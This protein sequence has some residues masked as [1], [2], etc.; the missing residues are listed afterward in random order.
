[1]EKKTRLWTVEELAAKFPAI[2]FPEY[3]R[4]PSVWSRDAKQRLIDSMM[5]EFDIASIYLYVHDDDSIECIDGRQRMNAIMSFLEDNPGDLDNGFEFR[6]LNEVFPDNG[7]PFRELDK[8]SYKRITQLRDSGE[9]VAAEFIDAFL[10]YELTVVFLKGSRAPE[11]FNLQF[12]RLNLGTII[13]SGEKLHAMVGELRDVCFKDIGKH[14]FFKR[15]RIPTRRYANEQVAA[16]LLVQA[17]SR[18]KPGDEAD[19]TRT[20]HFDLQTAFKQSL[21]LTPEE[22]AIVDRTRT[23]LDLL[24]SAFDE[25]NPLRNRAITVSVVLLAL[26]LDVT[27]EDAARQL[28]DFIN[29]FVCRLQWQIKK[30]VDIDDE[31]RHLLRFQR[32]LTQA[33]VE[34]AAVKERSEILK[35]EF[36]HWKTAH[37]YTGDD[38]YRKKTGDDPGVVCAANQ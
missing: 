9:K 30:G 8:T 29:G 13:N 5:R 23:T 36:E 26:E 38:A 35:Q 19:Y 16:Q 25:S 21:T 1:M 2:S 31:Y 28:A 17:L 27:D 34:K 7:H 15:T 33:S 10:A 4:E 11:E 3:Q 6:I 20:R 24:A 14:A 18:F 12:T 32:H 37:A 22:R